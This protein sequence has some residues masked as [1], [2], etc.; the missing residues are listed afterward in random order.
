MQQLELKLKAPD[1]SHWVV[2]S[3]YTVRMRI[4]RAKTMLLPASILFDTSSLLES[5]YISEN[6]HLR[7]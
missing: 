2:R 5:S 3:S 4:L 6:R 7:C 1:S